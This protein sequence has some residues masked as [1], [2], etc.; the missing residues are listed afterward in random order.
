LF[1]PI[2]SPN[3]LDPLDAPENN[4]FMEAE[5]MDKDGFGQLD[6]FAGDLDNPFGGD[7]LFMA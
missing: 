4:P 6:D 1:Q 2:S 3:A 5:P 7:D